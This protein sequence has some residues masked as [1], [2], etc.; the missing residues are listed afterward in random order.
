MHEPVVDGPSPPA[1]SAWFLL[2]IID[3]DSSSGGGQ[4]GSRC[5]GHSSHDDSSG[6]GWSVNVVVVVIIIVFVFVVDGTSRL[7]LLLSRSKRW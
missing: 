2:E 3:V 1:W 4:Q 5:G 7:D 6:G